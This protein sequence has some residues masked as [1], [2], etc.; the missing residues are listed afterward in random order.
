[1]V[2]PNHRS[3]MAS[4]FP[5][6]MMSVPRTSTP[7]H[8]AIPNR[9]HQFVMSW[10]VG[11]GSHES[12]GGDDDSGIDLQHHQ[13]LPQAG[14]GGRLPQVFCVDGPDDDVQEEYP[15]IFPSLLK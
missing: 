4:M 6:S 3:S 2:N 1:M 8:G 13:I 15:G 12:L 14:L 5:L 11:E 10:F 7:S 9:L